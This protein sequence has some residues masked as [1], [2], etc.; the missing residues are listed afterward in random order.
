ML[1][2]Y[3]FIGSFPYVRRIDVKSQKLTSL[4]I[5]FRLLSS[6]EV[7]VCQLADVPGSRG[8]RDDLEFLLGALV[9]VISLLSFYCRK[10]NPRRPGATLPGGALFKN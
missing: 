1:C 6:R 5:D 4:L 8:N 10:L 9:I 7:Q 3:K 2:G